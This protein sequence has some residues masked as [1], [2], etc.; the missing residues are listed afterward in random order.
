M[1]RFFN[2]T[3]PCRPDDHYML[4]PLPRL[5]MVRDL[6][7]RKAN[8]V[9][10]APRQSGKTTVLLSLA[11]ALTAEGRYAAVLLSLEVG[12][13]FTDDVGAAEDAI[14]S[15]W[16]LACKHWLPT[17]LQPPPWPSTEPGSAILVALQAWSRA[18]TVP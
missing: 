18:R 2:T 1:A 11:Q 8:F 7:E 10:H 6:I 9:L 3:G 14:L 5:P 17:A 16:R 4:P 12:D 15:S 13:P